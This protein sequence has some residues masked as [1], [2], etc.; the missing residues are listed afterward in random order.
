MVA[1]VLRVTLQVRK[2]AEAARKIA[3]KQLR[4]GGGVLDNALKSSQGPAGPSHMRLLSSA[5][6]AGA[7][8]LS[9]V[10]S[11]GCWCV[12]CP[13]PRFC[14]AI[15][16][17]SAWR[18]LLGLHVSL[19]RDSGLGRSRRVFW[20]LNAKRPLSA[21]KEASTDAAADAGLYFLE[22]LCGHVRV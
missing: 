4:S 13:G 1:E 19:A 5:G 8:G 15:E 18:K 7:E 14:Q 21:T 17:V 16:S 6:E 2:T 10:A 3:A 20:Q 9:Q 12:A 11:P 22:R